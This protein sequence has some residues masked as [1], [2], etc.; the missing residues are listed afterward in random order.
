MEFVMLKGFSL[1]RGAMATLAG[2]GLLLPPNLATAAEHTAAKPRVE[3]SQSSVLDLSIQEGGLK[4]RVVDHT[5]SPAKNQPVQVLQG[6]KKVAEVRTDER[7]EF[8]VPQMK[9]GLYDVA[10]GKTVGTYRLWR[11]DVAPPS[12]REQALLVLGENGAR[13]Q[14]G[15]LGS[16]GIIM[17]VATVAALIIAILAWNESQNNSD[18][19]EKLKKSP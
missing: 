12:T 13:G 8:S 10:S 18:E 4:G 19:I 16:G 2:L 3:I 5:G 6:G 7:G 15:S 1:L 14:F 9:S 17:A 11:A